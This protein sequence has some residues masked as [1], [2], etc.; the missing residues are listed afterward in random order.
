MSHIGD[1]IAIPLKIIYNCKEHLQKLVVIG[2]S[3]SFCNPKR[4]LHKQNVPFR[5]LIT[6][7]DL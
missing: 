1:V 2:S 4:V 3:S 6:Y 5:T 7:K